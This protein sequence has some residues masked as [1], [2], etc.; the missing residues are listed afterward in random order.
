MEGT[1]SP[2]HILDTCPSL[3]ATLWPLL[4]HLGS[5]CLLSVVVGW[6]VVSHPGPVLVSYVASK[7]SQL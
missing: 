4:V 7:L 3:G 5:R 6:L 1:R 2:F